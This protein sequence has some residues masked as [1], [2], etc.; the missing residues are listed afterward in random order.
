MQQ[1][2][3][4]F[5]DCTGTRTA[6]ESAQRCHHLDLGRNPKHRVPEV[7][8]AKWTTHEPEFVNLM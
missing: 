4:N 7:P 2:L 6:R 8:R 5:H 1:H 3:A